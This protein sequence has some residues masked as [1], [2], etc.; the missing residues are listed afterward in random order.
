MNVFLETKT[1]SGRALLHVIVEF[2]IQ[3]VLEHLLVLR[4]HLQFTNIPSGSSYPVPCSTVPP[5]SVSAL[6][7]FAAFRSTSCCPELSTHVD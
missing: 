3:F 5:S 7:A 6:S 1:E 2:C 4:I